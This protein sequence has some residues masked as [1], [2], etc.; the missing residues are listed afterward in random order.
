MG[1]FENEATPKFDGESMFITFI[2]HEFPIF[3]GI[4]WAFY[5]YTTMVHLLF[6]H[7]LTT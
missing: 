3:N 4:L 6:R 7:H 5:G 2:L 1:L